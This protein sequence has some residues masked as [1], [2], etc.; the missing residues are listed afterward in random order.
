MKQA[1]K[2][3]LVNKESGG[4]YRMDL[5]L[6]WVLDGVMLRLREQIVKALLPLRHRQ[7]PL[8][9]RLRHPLVQPRHLVRFPDRQERPRPER[10]AR[11][12]R[13]A[14]AVVA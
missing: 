9:R 6:L 2:D 10:R 14:D 1:Q 4:T 5:D 3:D 7:I 13:R 11:S 8:R 12:E